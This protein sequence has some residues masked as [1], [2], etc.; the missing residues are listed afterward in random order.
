MKIPDFHHHAYCPEMHG[1]SNVRTIG[2]LGDSVPSTG[3]NPDFVLEI[4]Q[5]FRQCHFAHDGE[6]GKHACDMCDA[7]ERFHGEFWVEVGDIRY[8]L[9]LAVFHYI[10]A[11]DYQLPAQFVEDL[12]LHWRSEASLSCRDGSCAAKNQNRKG[13]E[14]RSEVSCIP[15][16]PVKK[17]WRFWRQ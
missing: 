6:L 3:P 16:G 1:D 4:L 13:F 15:R 14:W 12:L 2:W 11:H 8:V 10:N 5:H 17:W 7:R 9:P